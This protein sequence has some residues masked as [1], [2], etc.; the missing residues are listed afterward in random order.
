M[1]IQSCLWVIPPRRINTRSKKCITQLLL[2]LEKK[3]KWTGPQIYRQSKG[4]TCLIV[5]RGVSLSPSLSITPFKNKNFFYINKL[6]LL[7]STN[8]SSFFLSYLFFLS[9]HSYPIFL[10]FISLL[11]LFKFLGLLFSYF[12]SS[13]SVNF[14]LALNFSWCTH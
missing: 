8:L 12:S 6:L 1:S 4:M 10:Y 13:S 14:V 11:S 9:L 5:W 7:T 2:C 3:G